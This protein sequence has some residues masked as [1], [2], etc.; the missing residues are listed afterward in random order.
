[1][2]KNEMTSALVDE[3]L[4]L[5]LMGA[6]VG[7]VVLAP[8]ALIGLNKPMKKAFDALDKRAQEREL[9]RV[10]QYMKH[11][12]LLAK[13]YQ[14]GLEITTLGRLRLKRMN[15]EKLTI[16]TPEVW[17]G[18]WRLVM[19]DI[20]ENK[21]HTRR[22]FTTKLRLLGYKYLQQSVWVHPFESK[23]EIIAVCEKLEISQYVTYIVT[24]HIDHESVLIDRFKALLTPA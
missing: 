23:Q 24:A 15:Y 12:K 9:A 5:A 19:F 20:P 22:I 13:N 4:R 21:R 18:Q 2:A 16:P 7:A 1:M 14:N 6:M 8:N 10:V 11:K 17:D 3:V